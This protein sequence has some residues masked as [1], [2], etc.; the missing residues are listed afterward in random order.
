MA[1]QMVQVS[2]DASSKPIITNFTMMSA[3]MNMPHGV[4]SRGSSAG[5]TS[6]ALG[7][8]AGDGAVSAGVAGEG[9]AAGAAGVAAGA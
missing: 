6:V 4:K 8:G 3:D 1:S 9:E 2:T 5:A 7:G